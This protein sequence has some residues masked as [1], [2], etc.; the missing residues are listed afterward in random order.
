MARKRIACFSHGEVSS[1]SSPGGG[2]VFCFGMESVRWDRLPALAPLNHSCL[3]HLNPSPHRLPSLQRWRRQHTVRGDAAPSV[4]ATPA[5]IAPEGT[6]EMDTGQPKGL[7]SSPR[8]LCHSWRSRGWPLKQ[9]A[10]ARGL[11]TRSPTIPW[12]RSHLTTWT[13][14]LLHNVKRGVGRQVTRLRE[15]TSNNDLERHQHT[16]HSLL[17]RNNGKMKHFTRVGSPNHRIKRKDLE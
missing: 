10:P 16:F 8:Y 3:W 15:K 5:H 4:S 17:T 1:L 7:P 14:S 12:H 6:R 2:C 11:T 9:R 13:A